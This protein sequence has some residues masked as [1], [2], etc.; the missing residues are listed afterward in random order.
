MNELVTIKDGT[1]GKPAVSA[2]ELYDKLGLPRQHWARWSKANIEENPFA[3]ENED[4]TTFTI[5][6]R[7]NETKDFLISIELA[8]KLC[9]LTRTEVGERIRNYFIECERVAK[10]SEYKIPYHLRRHM[11]NINKIPHTHFSIL[12][13]LIIKLVAPLE[14][15]GYTLPDDMLPDISEGKMF[16]KY[17]RDEKGINT[18]ILQTYEQIYEDGRVVY[19]KLY[20]IEIYP[21]FVNHF[22]DVWLPQKAKAYFTKRDPAA[23]PYLEKH[24]RQ[25]PAST[26][27]VTEKLANPDEEPTQ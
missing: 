27:Q 19:P 15:L 17:L 5:V 14:A 13:E 11:A 21:D 3:S 20:P 6:V 8:K 10:Q 9:M 1:D 4:W 23:L 18:D 25:L 22:F 26:I 7:G 2:K 16:C 12:T 24:L